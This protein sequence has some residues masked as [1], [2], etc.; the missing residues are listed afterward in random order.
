VHDE[1]A[2]ATTRHRARVPRPIEVAPT[3]QRDPPAAK[4][5]LSVVLLR[6]AGYCRHCQLIAAGSRTAAA[7]LS[8]RCRVPNVTVA[9]CIRVGND[10]VWFVGVSE[11]QHDIANAVA[12]LA[13]P[14]A[15]FIT[16]Q[17]ISVDGGPVMG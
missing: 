10:V 2:G 11:A 16:G 17:A 14:E 8:R 3:R 13:S 7:P 15:S 1:N 5:H 4:P 6:E 9:R 12:F